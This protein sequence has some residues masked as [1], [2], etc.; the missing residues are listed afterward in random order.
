MRMSAERG[1]EL[2]HLIMVTGKSK[3]HNAE[4]VSRLQTQVNA[5][6]FETEYFLLVLKAFN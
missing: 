1:E 6:V 4:Q 3:I 2:A 5:V